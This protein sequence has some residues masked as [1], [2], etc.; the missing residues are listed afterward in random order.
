MHADVYVLV[1]IDVFRCHQ[2]SKE[3]IISPDCG[4]TLGCEPPNVGD[5]NSV[6]VL[7]KGSNH[8]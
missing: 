5:G 4:A 2:R 6:P 3:S 1:C 8:F 7:Y